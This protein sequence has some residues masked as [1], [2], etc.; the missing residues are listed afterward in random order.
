MKKVITIVICVS[1]L[2][3]TLAACSQAP[4]PAAT[5]DAPAPAPAATTDAPAA[6]AGA[7]SMGDGAYA[8]PAKPYKVG[9]SNGMI[10]NGWRNQMT[11]DI[12]RLAELY[13]ERGWVDSITV[14][15]AGIDN[16]AQIQHIRAMI[17]EGCDLI[18]VDPNSMDAMNPVM[19]EALD[20]GAL[21]LST[22]QG[23]TSKRVLS[24][25]TDYA[26]WNAELARWLCEKLGGQGDILLVSGIAGNSANVERLN[27]CF[28]VLDQYPGINVLTE[29]NGDWD[30]SVAQ[31]AVASV[32]SSYPKIDGVLGQDGLML[33]TVQAFEAAGRELPPMSGE[34]MKG[35]LVK[36]QELKNSQGF[37]TV[38]LL[39]PPGV[40]ATALGIGCR[41]LLGYEFKD[42]II[43]TRN[44]ITGFFQP[45]AEPITNDNLDAFLDSLVA[46]SDAYY[47]DYYLSETELDALFK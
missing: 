22:D 7:P 16:N 11:D 26:A 29:V 10:G 40:S 19:E 6:A 34:T 5:T 35:F 2:V 39:N 3:L 4:T 46:Q 18:I 37:E 30:Q 28:E 38:G 33:G 23:V 42:G 13:K 44:G 12:L 27:A 32:L 47:P 15:H 21:V 41:M 25:K 45:F 14:Q 24:I 1:L 8:M 36:W 43:E 20:A 9:F 31:Q 17:Q